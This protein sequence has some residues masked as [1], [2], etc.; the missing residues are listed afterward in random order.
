MT[1]YEMI[2][3]GDEPDLFTKEDWSKL[4]KGLITDERIIEAMLAEGYDAAI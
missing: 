3:G 4:G 2:M 1:L